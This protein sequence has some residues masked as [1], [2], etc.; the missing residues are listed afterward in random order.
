MK[1]FRKHTVS[2]PHTFFHCAC[3][4]QVHSRNKAFRSEAEKKALLE[5][6]SKIT[7]EFSGAEL[8]NVL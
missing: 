6:V 2:A 4:A 3:V 7:F 1:M 8:Q 5:E